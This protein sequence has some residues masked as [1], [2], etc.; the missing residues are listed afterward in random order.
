MATEGLLRQTRM[1]ERVPCVFLSGTYLLTIGLEDA[2]RSVFC[3]GTC[4]QK[5]D[6]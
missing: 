5:W 1:R 4:R 6:E 2:T 3:A